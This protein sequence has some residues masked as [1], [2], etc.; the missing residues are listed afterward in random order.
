MLEDVLRNVSIIL[1]SILL[2]DVLLSMGM[3]HG[4]T[5]QNIVYKNKIAAH[6][7][8][9]AITTWQINQEATR[10][11][12]S[13]REA[14]EVLSEKIFIV[15]EFVRIRGQLPENY[16]QKECDK[17]RKT[18]FD[19]DY[20]KFSDAL[21]KNGKTKQS[22][23]NELREK[24]IVGFMYDCN[25]TRPSTVSPLDTQ[26]YYNAHKS[27]MKQGR[28]ISFDQI[29]ISKENQKSI[30]DVKKCIKS[31]N[32]YEEIFERLSKIPNANINRND[33]LLCADIL[34]TVVQ[35]VE[36]MALNSFSDEGIEL[37]NHIMFFGLRK[38]KEERLLTLTEA[39]ANI[40]RILLNKRYQQLRQDWLD[41]LRKKAHYIV[42]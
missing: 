24:A 11:K 41:S 27:E 3:L 38:I 42:I 12:I 6:V 28:Q 8:N 7:E 39:S 33:D 35:K 36:T 29:A 25:V 9:R 40:E 17:I 21:K 37:G 23:E 4:S 20:L 30:E 22:F 26:N 32:N 31:G 15:C 13:H 1:R 19:N 18:R 5:A 34:P 2:P 16:A 10:S 14:L